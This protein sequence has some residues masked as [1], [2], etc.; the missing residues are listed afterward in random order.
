VPLIGTGYDHVKAVGAEVYR[1]HDP[2]GVDGRSWLR[3]GQGRCC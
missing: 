1:R 2:R 3:L